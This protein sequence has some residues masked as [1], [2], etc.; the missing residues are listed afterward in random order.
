MAYLGVFRCNPK[1]ARSALLRYAVTEARTADFYLTNNNGF[2]RS[3]VDIKVVI[4]GESC[5][6]WEL[7][8]CNLYAVPSPALYTVAVGSLPTW[9]RGCWYGMLP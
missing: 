8:L 6:E 3:I 2:Q 7:V 4:K 1:F 9:L 5:F